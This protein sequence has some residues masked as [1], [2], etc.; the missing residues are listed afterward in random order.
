[1]NY[2]HIRSERHGHILTITLNRPEVLNALQPLTCRELA[3][4]FRDYLTDDE[5]RVAVFT[6][7]GERAFCVGADLKYRVTTED[8]PPQGGLPSDEL[9]SILA[10]ANK[11]VI[12]SVNGY[13]LAGGLEMALRCDLIIAAAHAQF[14]L[15]EVKRGLLADGGG[16]YELS[17]RIPYHQALGLVLTG[18]S[19]TA[20]EALQ[21]GLVN[22][23]APKGEL[24]AVTRQWADQIA[25]HSP[26]AV[27]AAKETF[28]TFR[29]SAARPSL[30]EIDA[31]PTVALLRASEDYIEGPRAFAEKRLPVWSGRPRADVATPPISHRL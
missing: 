24:A 20:E 11:P 26:V 1:M 12:A 6:G 31:L 27:Q 7:A 15:P 29:H 25:A 13:A 8:E 17:Q 18:R 3:A 19:I 2:Q 10:R 30:A 22:A 9:D 5:L 4:A 28:R 16:T 14:G 23:V 21:M